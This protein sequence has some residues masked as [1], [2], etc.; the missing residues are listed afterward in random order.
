LQVYSQRQD[1]RSYYQISNV[2][3]DR[4]QVNGQLRQVMLAARE[5]NVNNLTG[6]N[7]WVNQHLFYTHG[8][9]LVMSPVNEVNQDKGGPVFFV[10]DIPPHS[11]VNGLTVTRPELYFGENESGYAVVRSS[12]PEF[13]YPSGD[14]NASTVY[15]GNAGISLRN[16]LVRALAAYRF[17]DVDLLISNAINSQSR[18]IFRRQIIDRVQTLA[19][20]LKY[21]T[22]P[23]LVVGTDGKLYWMMDA[24]T[25]SDQYPYAKV[26]TLHA[27]D[28]DTDVNYVRNSVK[29]V[30]DAYNGSVNFYLSD[31][32]DP[33]IRAWQSIFPGM[34]QPLSAMPAG[35]IQHIRVPE[36]MFNT[37]SDIY[38]R[39]H[40]TEDQVKVFFQNEDQWD[41]PQEAKDLTANSAK[42]DMEG[43]YVT[44]SLPGQTDPEYLLIRPFTPSGKLNMI[45]WLSARSDPGHYGELLVYDFPKQSQIYGPEQMR[46]SINQDPDISSAISLWNQNGSQVLW[47][48]LMVIPIG[49]TVLYVQPLYLQASQSQIPELQ[50]VIVGDQQQVKM[51]N[52]L[53]EALAALT[54]APLTSTPAVAPSTTP[55][56]VSTAPS[57]G[58]TPSATPSGINPTLAHSAQDH[59]QRADDAARKGDWGT[60][61]KEL[62]ALKHDIEA[63][64]KR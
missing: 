35:L 11:T 44:M 14:A 56:P 45:A 2:D 63:M 7:P 18:L 43:Y 37:L 49:T 52:T 5:L 12:Q 15:S 22:D 62:D 31:P 16:L 20:F 34:F 64:N 10:S 1:L 54:G 29:V 28:G 59:L 27:A 47:G 21:D 25:K 46:A 36:G 60:Y 48:N 17:G 6:A 8:Y 24:Y 3:V 51:R 40:L 19:P 39:Y 30:I 26:T 55:A 9:G 61:G 38:R 41:I 23:Y 42:T 50:R 57:A 4:Y 58:V 32:R 53:D 33:L 13:D